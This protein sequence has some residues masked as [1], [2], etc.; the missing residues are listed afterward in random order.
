MDEALDFESSS[1][2]SA[3]ESSTPTSS[4]SS[5]STKL[6][7]AQFDY[8]SQGQKNSLGEKDL[9]FKKGEIMSLIDR[10]TNWLLVELNSEIG[11]LEFILLFSLFF[12]KSKV[13]CLQITYNL[14]Q[15]V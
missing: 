15:K 2:S 9:S 13:W 14:F 11:K 1:K 5:N 4:S 12:L 3:T 6:F 7:V 10:R 8:T